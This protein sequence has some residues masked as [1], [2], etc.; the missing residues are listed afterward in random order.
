MTKRQPYATVLIGS[1]I[2]L[3]E[4]LGRILRNADF[5]VLSSTARLDDTVLCSL[6]QQQSILLVA[7]GG[8]HADDVTEQIE[9]YK[10]RRVDG[11]VAVV[12]DH[13]ELNDVVSVFRAG[14]DACLVRVATGEI[15]VKYLE[16]VMMGETIV[17]RALLSFTMRPSPGLALSIHPRGEETAGERRSSPTDSVGLDTPRLSTREKF[18]LHCLVVG[19]S[20]KAIARKTQSAEGTVK[21]HVKAILRKVRVQNRTQAAIWAM[22]HKGLIVEDVADGNSV[23]AN[24]PFHAIEKAE[25]A[26]PI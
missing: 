11:R 10:T 9:R 22:G 15:L 6:P 17:P 7:D 8:D 4:G 24:G 13:Y 25:P 14:A 18:I 12:A 3:R 26:T 23:P 1:S 19:D 16:L 5:R 2:L 20:N 21:V